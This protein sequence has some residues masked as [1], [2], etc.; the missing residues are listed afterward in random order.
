MPR[1]DPDF[2]DTEVPP[3]F[4]DE[5]GRPHWHEADRNGDHADED[6]APPRQR[7]ATRRMSSVAP[8]DVTWLWFGRLPLGKVV[9]LDG[10]PAVGKSTMTTDLAARVSTGAA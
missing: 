7:L 9:V 4:I 6:A 1:A 10:D 5:H 3:H 2:D 8:E